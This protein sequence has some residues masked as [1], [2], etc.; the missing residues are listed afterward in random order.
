MRTYR[1]ITF[2]IHGFVIF[3]IGNLD[4]FVKKVTF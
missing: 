2:H 1:V 4:G 3:K